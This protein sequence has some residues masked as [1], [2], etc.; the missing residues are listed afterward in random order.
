VVKYF[1]TIFILFSLSACS[2]GGG[3][4]SGGGGGTSSTG[5][6]TFSSLAHN[7]S[8]NVCFSTTTI[9]TPASCSVSGTPTNQTSTATCNVGTPTAVCRVSGVNY[10]LSAGGS[11]SA[12]QACVNAGGTVQVTCPITTNGAC[13][14]ATGTWTPANNPNVSNST[15]CTNAG[16]VFYTTLENLTGSMPTANLSVGNNIITADPSDVAT[17]LSLFNG[18]SD[19]DNTNLSL[20][21]LSATA[22]IGSYWEHAFY[23]TSFSVYNFRSSSVQFS[24]NSPMATTSAISIKTNS[25]IAYYH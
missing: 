17:A 18:T 7:S 2:S 23:M 5:S 22:A 25:T 9:G 6:A 10:S 21:A 15:N 14:G 11:S 1:S 19:L 13:T 4:S 3:D 24:A 16:G 20:V 12:D 8:S